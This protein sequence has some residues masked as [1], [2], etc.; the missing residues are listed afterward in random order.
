MLSYALRLVIRS[1]PD[2]S[3]TFTGIL[4][5]QPSEIVGAMEI[6][7]NRMD[8]FLSQ[9]SELASIEI[10]ESTHQFSGKVVRPILAEDFVFKFEKH[11]IS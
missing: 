9:W 5:S 2:L 1:D 3:A 4:P 11:P 6:I 10:D 7:E 8:A